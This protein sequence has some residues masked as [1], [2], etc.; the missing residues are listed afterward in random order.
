MQGLLCSSENGNCI[1][2][3]LIFMSD[4]QGARIVFHLMYSSPIFNDLRISGINPCPVKQKFPEN[5]CLLGVF[6]H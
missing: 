2:C 1:Y 5:V 6:I 4:R 3:I